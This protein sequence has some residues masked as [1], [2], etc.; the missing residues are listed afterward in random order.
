MVLLV[1][2][3]KVD[4]GGQE[5]NIG[6]EEGEGGSLGMCLG[7]EEFF[8]INRERSRRLFVV[9]AKSKHS[10]FSAGSNGRREKFQMVGSRGR[11]RISKGKRGE[12]RRWEEGF[13]DDGLGS[14][15]CRAQHTWS[16]T[17]CRRID[18][19]VVLSGSRGWTP[20]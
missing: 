3:K 13:N 8:R 14:R 18:L 10:F 15:I 7:F 2:G 9:R 16:N 20:L 11:G 17:D 6:D 1:V 19:F 4:M 12:R 5:E